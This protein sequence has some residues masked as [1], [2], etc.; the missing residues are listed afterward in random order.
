MVTKLPTNS[1]VEIT[2]FK[3]LADWVQE[4]SGGIFFPAMLFGMF[5]IFFMMLKSNYTS[6]KA[7]A[8]TSFVCMIIGIMLSVLGWLSSGYMYALI[9]MTAFGVVWAYLED[10]E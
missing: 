1:T 6:G 9:L 4:A 7:F 8:G 2:G 3:S 10:T 5:V